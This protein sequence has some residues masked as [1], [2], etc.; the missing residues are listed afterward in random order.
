MV[1]VRI[2]NGLVR[3]D[4]GFGTSASLG[5]NYLIKDRISSGEELFHFGFGESPFPVPLPFLQ[6]LIENAHKNEYLNSQGLSSLREKLIRFHKVQGDFDHFT[7]DDVVLAAGSK[8]LIY[9]MINV[10]SGDILMPSPCWMSYAPQSV[11][12]NKS[13]FIIETDFENRYIPTARNIETTLSLTDPDTPKLLILNFPSNP[14]GQ[15]PTEK[16]LIE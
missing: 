9:H 12:S 8:E 10:F 6:G 15:M 1:I 13:Y 11:L 3:E 16:Q 2:N 7:P 4:L 14:T 5:L